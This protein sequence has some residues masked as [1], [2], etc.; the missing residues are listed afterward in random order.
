[1][2]SGWMDKGKKIKSRWKNI[3]RKWN[4]GELILAN[5]LIQGESIL[6]E[7]LKNQMKSGW[8]DIGKKFNPGWINIGKE[9]K[10]M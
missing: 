2:K 9:I 8:I 10:N 1:M 6:A 5:F 3:D 7:R 4:Q